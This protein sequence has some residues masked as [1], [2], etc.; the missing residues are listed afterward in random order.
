[1]VS[2]KDGPDQK[3]NILKT[4]ERTCRK[5][6]HVYYKN[7]IIYNSK[8]MTNI[9]CKWKRLYVKVNRKILSQEILTW[10]IKPLALTVQKI[11]ARFSKNRSNSKVNGHRVTNVGTQGKV[12]SQ[13]KIYLIYHSS[14]IHFSKVISKGKVFKKTNL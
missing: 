9:F 3:T 6:K 10:N 14:S 11:I 8:V 12:L 13:G 4:V 5:N 2:S 1:M 7:S